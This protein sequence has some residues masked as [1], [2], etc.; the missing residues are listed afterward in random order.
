MI[1]EIK[2]LSVNQA[3]QG[4]KFKTNKYKTWR[5][6][7]GWLAY[8]WVKGRKKKIYKG[9]LAVKITVFIS[10]KVYKKSD[11]D[12]FCKPIL[13]AMVESKIIED[14]RFVRILS[15]SKYQSENEGNDI[16]IKELDNL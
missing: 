4:R 2:P 13:D 1:F 8:Q 16:D 5:E 15:I 6:E 3:W 9:E 7:F 14:D 11:V 10:P 12:N